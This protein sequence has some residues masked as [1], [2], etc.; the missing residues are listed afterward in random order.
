MI[1]LLHPLPFRHRV[2]HR[3]RL[4][5]Y[6]RLIVGRT[7]L[8]TSI[9]LES[10]H[11][12]AKLTLFLAWYRGLARFIGGAPHPLRLAR[13]R[14]LPLVINTRARV[15]L[16]IRPMIS[17]TRNINPWK[18]TITYA[19]PETRKKQKFTRKDGRKQFMLLFLQVA[20][21]DVTT[22][23]GVPLIFY[24]CMVNR[25]LILFYW[26]FR[27]NTQMKLKS[28]LFKF[29][30]MYILNRKDTT[31]RLRNTLQ[32]CN[33]RALTSLLRI[34]RLIV[35]VLLRKGSWKLVLLLLIG[36]SKHLHRLLNMISCLFAFL[37][38]VATT[39]VPFR[40]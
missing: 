10:E 1:P 2:G 39:L 18:G 3:Y 4:T 16:L 29:T 12:K 13:R 27:Q 20:C 24:P 26:K 32:R 6:R 9:A 17:P 25:P 33:P 7:S 31:R 21:L 30:W 14:P 19:R 34:N 40:L 28:I 37:V 23:H 22:R 11:I 5:H 8:Q 35:F 36:N 15:P 38:R